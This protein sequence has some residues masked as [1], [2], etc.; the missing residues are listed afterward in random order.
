MKKSNNL[1][2][3]GFT[4]IELLVVIAI[5]ALLMAVILPALQ[6]AKV[7]AEEV[8]C[9]SNIRQYGLAT[10]MYTS[11][12]NDVV[13]DPWL[14]LFDSCQNQ[15][16]NNQICTVGAHLTYP[17]VN[18]RP[19]E[20]QRYCRWHN[21]EFSLEA[22]PELAGPYWQYL[23]VTKANICPTFAK[24]APKYGPEHMAG[25]G[26]MTAGSCIGEPFIPQFSYSMN[27]IFRRSV[28]GVA[29]TV[30]KSQV[31]SP[32]QTF[33]WAEENMW[34]LTDFS[35]YVLND[36]ALLVNMSTG[37]TDNFAS[38]HK[39]SAAKLEIQQDAHEYESDSGVSNA[40]LVDGSLHWVTPEQGRDYKGRVQ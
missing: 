14:S 3:F 15:C 33:L 37:Y 1:K 40:L 32:S 12:N 36:T 25:N 10:E 7:Y 29:V 16:P 20:T 13:P 38:F 11:E 18:G 35:T 4:L 2:R 19:A 17:S 23:A 24:L 8:L 6:K 31:K 5:I 27:T 34:T 9:K 22:Y 39:I 26:G 28:N 30:K 21:P